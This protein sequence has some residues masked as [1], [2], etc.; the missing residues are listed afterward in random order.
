MLSDNE[1]DYL[2]DIDPLEPSLV[3][4]SNSLE[5]SPALLSIATTSAETVQS[6]IPSPTAEAPT[7]PAP[8]GRLKTIRSKRKT[9]SQPDYQTAII[10]YQTKKLDFEERRWMTELRVTE[11]RNALDRE[12]LVMEKRR[13]DL[14]LA[15]MEMDNKKHFILCRNE[16]RSNGVSQE[17]IDAMF[18]F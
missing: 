14:E 5:T 15:K 17:E 13:A 1:D 16:L 6:L 2:V 4:S 18:P 10:D 3:E 8:V 7:T 11:D 9:P 12:R